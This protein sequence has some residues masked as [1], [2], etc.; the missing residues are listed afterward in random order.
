MNNKLSTR[1]EKK[2]DIEMVIVFSIL[3]FSLLFFIQRLR[4]QVCDD[5]MIMKLI[6]G[7]YTGKPSIHGVFVI[8][9][10]TLI[11][12]VL[13]L[14][15]NKLDWYAISLI[16]CECIFY[17]I[18]MYKIIKRI[19]NRNA[20]II[21]LLISSLL[22]TLFFPTYLS[23]ITFTEVS[24]FVMICIN[25]LFLLYE[26]KKSEKILIILGTAIAYT[27][28]SS[29]CMMML[30]MLVPIGLY[31]SYKDRQKLKEYFVLALEVTIGIA[32]IIVSN[33]ILDSTSGWKQYNKYNVIRS[34]FYDYYAEEI[35]KF[36]DEKRKE[37]YEKSGITNEEADLIFSYYLGLDEKSPT[38]LEKLVETYEKYYYNVQFNDIS[39]TA[40][41]MIKNYKIY[42]FLI[43][44]LFLLNF[45]TAIIKKDW[46]LLILLIEL[47]SVLIIIL[48]YLIFKG[49]IIDRVMKPLFFYNIVIYFII[50]FFN[51][52]IRYNY[53]EI[54]N[55]K[56]IFIIVVLLLTF[57][58]I[59]SSK[60]MGEIESAKRIEIS[61]DQYYKENIDKFYIYAVGHGAGEE[62]IHLIRDNSEN[63]CMSFG[64]WIAFSPAYYEKL[65]NN[66]VKNIKELCLKD[67]VYVVLNY[68]RKIEDIGILDETLK[69]EK[70]EELDKVYTKFYVYRI[71]NKDEDE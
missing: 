41:D 18:T 16:L 21:T 38:K 37:L 3:F 30:P 56:T 53:E 55:N 15:N 35:S 58:E 54:C 10:F 32:L 26:G 64:D 28:R 47:T 34:K 69:Y 61:N 70:V 13:Y 29:G 71:M 31:K 39:N 45:I 52:D 43:G 33:N 11:L 66:H 20:K 7:Q 40:K 23:Q 44:G 12:K 2:Y 62:T 4:Y 14:I 27:I 63:N 8:F 22:I 6:S 67:N 68:K 65:S 57:I 36:P 42:I 50:L 60:K 19:N 59:I 5:V 46:K 1:N 49:R 9:P 24:I 25:I 48:S 17:S 51:K